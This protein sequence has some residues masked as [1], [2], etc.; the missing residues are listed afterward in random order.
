[1]I[2][3]LLDMKELRII[4]DYENADLD[5]VFERGEVEARVASTGTVIQHDQGNKKSVDFHAAN[6]APPEKKDSRFAHL[7][8]PDVEPSP[9]AKRSENCWR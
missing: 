1:M 4:P 9:K 6:E 3:Y 2:A 7:N 5:V 8:L